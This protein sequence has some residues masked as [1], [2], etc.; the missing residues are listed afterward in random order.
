[1][2]ARL[3]PVALALAWGLLVSVGL[4]AVVRAIQFFIFPDPNPA[5]VVW[6]AHA[7]YFWRVWT[8]VFAGGLAAFS[9]YVAALRGAERV[10]RGLVPGL[11]VTTIL[12]GVQVALLP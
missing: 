11:F 6:S 10:A 8:V 5:L 2:K 7:G 4:Y 9:A 1:M 3:V 12:V